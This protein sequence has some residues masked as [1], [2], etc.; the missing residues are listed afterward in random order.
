[1]RSQPGHGDLF[2]GNIGVVAYDHSY[3]KPLCAGTSGATVMNTSRVFSPLGNLTTDCGA[4]FDVGAVYS[5]YT[6]TM[7]TDTIGFARAV[8]FS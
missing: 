1:L 4:T 8:L 6:P 2:I 7:A 5:A 3:A